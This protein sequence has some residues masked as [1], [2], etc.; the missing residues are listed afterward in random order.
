MIR[1]SLIVVSLLYGLFSAWVFRHT[2]NLPALRTSRRRLTAYLMELRLFSSEP[3][4][5]WSA[6]KSLLRENAR[7]F[8][9]LFRPVLILAVPSSFLLFGLEPIYGWDPLPAG[10][11]AV[12]T[13]QL[14]RPLLPSDA[15]DRLEAP[16]GIAVET[17]PVRSLAD[18]RISWRIRPISQSRGPLH[19]SVAGAGG[20]A[21]ISVNYPPSNWLLWFFSISTLGALIFALGVKL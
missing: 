14:N 12:V 19:F 9:L 2:A 8:R 11:A 3:A 7:L 17:S 16:T 18:R 1:V 15:E 4:L 5:L 10:Q 6:Q 13:A 21:G 20:V